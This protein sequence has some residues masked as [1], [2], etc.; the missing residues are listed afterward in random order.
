MIGQSGQ[1]R[2]EPE[3][4]IIDVDFNTRIHSFVETNIVNASFSC[5]KKSQGGQGGECGGRVEDVAESRGCRG[6]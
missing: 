1:R 6:G 4:S 2:D 5:R 3:V